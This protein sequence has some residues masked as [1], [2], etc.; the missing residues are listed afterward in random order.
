MEDNLSSAMQQ[1]FNEKMIALKMSSQNVPLFREWLLQQWNFLSFKIYSHC[2]IE[3][4]P[5]SMIQKLTRDYGMALGQKH[6]T[7]VIIFWQ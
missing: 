1:K 2:Y 5:N 4:R 7:D 3:H 6:W